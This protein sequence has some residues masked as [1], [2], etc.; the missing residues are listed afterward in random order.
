LGWHAA[1]REYF[2]CSFMTERFYDEQEEQSAVKTAIV[3]KYFRPWSTIMLR[4]VRKIAY[5]DFF[6]GPG[7]FKDGNESTPLLILRE[8]LKSPILRSGL[9]AKFNDINPNYTAQCQSE[10]IRLPNI[11]RMVHTPEVQTHTVEDHYADEFAGVRD[12]PTLSFIDPWGY[13]G[14]TLKLVQQLI[15]GFG[16][17]AIFFFNYSRINAAISDNFVETHVAA[18]F[19]QARL[20]ELR[21]RLL[22]LSGPQREDLI[23]RELGASFEEMGSHYL[24][25]FRFLRESGYSHYICF[26][27]KHPLGYSIMKDVMA[28][29][30]IRDVDGVPKFTYVPSVP[31]SQKEFDFDIDR[32]LLSLPS[33]L[34]SRFAGRTLAVEAIH[35]EHN[36]GT[37]FVL[38]NYQRVLLDLESQ[39]VISVRSTKSRR[40]PGTMAKHLLVTF[41][42]R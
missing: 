29:L 1:D 19:G 40:P 41:P 18:I 13:K 6:S 12:M 16:S 5:L 15:T 22:Q 35:E 42:G 36:V 38:R 30:G 23:I 33:A 10:I 28:S 4:Q 21:S 2:S 7:R 37:P 8:A 17:E 3:V 34:R 25:P 39:G 27:T 31:T 24:I 9:I 20:R 26:V 14:L 11:E 32:P